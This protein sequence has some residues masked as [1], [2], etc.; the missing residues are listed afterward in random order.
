MAGRVALVFT[1]AKA[2]QERLSSGTGFLEWFTAWASTIPVGN[3]KLVKAGHE[4]VIKTTL[5]SALK[6]SVQQAR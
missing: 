4:S 6:T 1:L 5:L 2:T 3:G